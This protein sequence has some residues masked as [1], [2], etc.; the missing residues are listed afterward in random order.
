M[1]EGKG[2]HGTWKKSF[3]SL[4]FFSP[5][6]IY[7]LFPFVFEHFP[8]PS[9]DKKPRAVSPFRNT[10][11]PYR[12]RRIDKRDDGEKTRERDIGVLF[13]FVWKSY[14]Y[15]VNKITWKN[16]GTR[17]VVF[18]LVFFYRFVDSQ[19]PPDAFLIFSPVRSVAERR[20]E[21]SLLGSYFNAEIDGPRQLRGQNWMGHGETY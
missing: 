7:V 10:A 19:R 4:S 14:E 9:R 20:G 18:S 11:L 1:G 16:K 5:I 21:R 8:C 15:K 12:L 6:F 2:T 13:S 3:V 17:H